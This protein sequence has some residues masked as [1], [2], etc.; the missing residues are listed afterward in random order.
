LFKL[1][2]EVDLKKIIMISLFFFALEATAYCG[3][4]SKIE[5]TDGSI[6]NGEIVSYVNNVYT[7]NTATFGEIKVEA[8]NVSKIESANYASANPSYRPI[9]NTDNSAQSQ[10]LA[11]GQ[12]LMKNP[13]NAAIIAELA[14]DPQFQ[15]MAS[16]PRIIDAAKTGDMKALTGNAKFM[17]IVNSPKMQEALKKLKE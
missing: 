1:K 8:A 7:I 6:I 13:E 10:A 12:T 2:P 5:L 11:Y 17:D 3:Q 4:L 16:D 15:A 9:V 14:S